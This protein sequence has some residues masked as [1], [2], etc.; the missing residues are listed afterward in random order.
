MVGETNQLDL[1]GNENDQASSVRVRPSCTLKL[2][3][4]SNNVGLLDSLTSDVSV[5]SYNDQVSSVSCTCRAGLA[6]GCPSDD[7]A[8]QNTQ[9]IIS[10]TTQ[11]AFVRCCSK[12][13]GSCKIPDCSRLTFSNAEQKCSE[14]GMRL[15]TKE[16]LASNICC[17][18]GC[19]YD[20]KLVWY[21]KGNMFCSNIKNILIDL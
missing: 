5:L 14:S 4:H 12:I 15:C 18:T 10:T 3:K 2:Y 9:D 21:T 16:E 13:G 8:I 1:I 7:N 6:S 17:K 20:R 19:G 11:T